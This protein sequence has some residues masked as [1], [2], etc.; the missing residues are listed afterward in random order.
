MLKRVNLSIE[1]AN[2]VIA[3]RLKVPKRF[4]E[5]TYSKFPKFI[6]SNKEKTIVSTKRKAY[7]DLI[8]KRLTK[9]SNLTSYVGKQDFLWIG[10]TSKRI[11]IHI[12]TVYL[13]HKNGIENFQVSLS[14]F[15]QLSKD[16]HIRLYKS[17][18]NQ[19]INGTKTSV[20]GSIYSNVYLYQDDTNADILTS[21]FKNSELKYLN[22]E[23]I[24]KNRSIFIAKQLP[25]L[26]KYRFIIEYAQKIKAYGIANDI[27]GEMNYGYY[28]SMK[29]THA[30]MSKVTMKFLKT[31]KVAL[32]NTNE[33]YE[34]FI[35]HF[36]LNQYLKKRYG[37]A[38]DGFS[39]LFKTINELSILPETVKPI[40]F[41][42]WAVKQGVKYEEYK[43]YRETIIKMGMIFTG[44]Y[45]V[46]PKDFYK[47][48]QEARDNLAA[49]EEA[50]LLKTFNKRVA[51]LK[52]IEDEIRG[53]SFIIPRTIQEI[54][55]EGKELHHCVASYANDHLKGKTTIM[56]VRKKNNLNKPLYTMEIK[57]NKIVQIRGKSNS[58]PPKKVSEA[59]EIF[60]SH[61]IESDINI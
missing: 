43:A 29:H 37:H 23:Q 42:N 47:S 25:H 2:K 49:I 11:E 34:D 59:A 10:A 20:N 9:K 31:H 46:I 41:Q 1:E 48:F 12:Y 39:H 30:N 13:S 32:R 60:L 38:V 26:Y 44:D 56:F 21:L 58:I 40:R 19:Y 3:A 61:V 17:F 36:N 33:K 4:F 57:D 51:N 45:L 50:K 28:G 22:F 35:Q 14:Q 5:E 15:E 53:Y 7:S 8:V 27:I 6:W 24:T 16:K 54:R 52:K 18:G 55:D